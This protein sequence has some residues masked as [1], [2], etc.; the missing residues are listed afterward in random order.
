M[1]TGLLSC[2][3]KKILR[4]VN[5][6]NYSLVNMKNYSRNGGTCRGLLSFAKLY[7]DVILCRDFMPPAAVIHC[8]SVS[9][10]ENAI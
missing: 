8:Y 3:D 5:M 9:Y 7:T 10:F 2:R 6:K 4:S 1:K